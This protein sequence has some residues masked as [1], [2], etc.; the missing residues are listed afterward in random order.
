MRRPSA[1]PPAARCALN[2]E[3]IIE[4]TS[5]HH[6]AEVDDRAGVTQDARSLARRIKKMGVAGQ[7]T[8]ARAHR[9]RRVM[10]R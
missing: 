5:K 9:R 8:A 7:P 1:P 10:P 6:A 4:Y 3:P 2:K